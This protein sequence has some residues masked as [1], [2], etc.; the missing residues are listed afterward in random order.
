MLKL[1]SRH[2]VNWQFDP[3]QNDFQAR[4]VMDTPGYFFRDDALLLNGA[5]QAFVNN[6]VTNYY[7]NN[8]AVQGD[9]E[10]QQFQA[11]LILGRG[12]TGPNGCGMVG[13][14]PF[15]NIQNLVNVLTHFIYICSVEHSA[16]NFPQYEQYAFPPN[17]AA[18]LH[19]QPEQNLSL[20]DC[21]PTRRETFSTIKIMKVLTLSLTSSLGNYDDKY[22][23]AMDAAGI[24]S[25]ALFQGNL[26]AIRDQINLRNDNIVAVNNPNLIQEYPYEWLLPQNVL[27]SISI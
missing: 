6:Y 15:N 25:V 2:N 9:P 4:G 10:I 21:M 19:G 16:T 8:A 7:G 17:F 14:P 20:D 24:A 23:S 13:L 11:E 27:N 3:I 5:I 18:V 22:L 26:N 1:I 12:F